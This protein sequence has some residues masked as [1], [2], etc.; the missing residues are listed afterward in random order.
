MKY[1]CTYFTLSFILFCWRLKILFIASCISFGAHP[2]SYT[3]S[4]SRDALLCT[5]LLTTAS[6]SVFLPFAV[7]NALALIQ[8]PSVALAFILFLKWIA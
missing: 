6:S 4:S 1:M 7:N 2:L 5:S 3:C 8:A